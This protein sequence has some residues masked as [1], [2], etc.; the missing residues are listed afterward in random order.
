MPWKFKCTAGD[1]AG[2]WATLPVPSHWDMH[3]FGSLNYRKDPDAAHNEQGL[4]EYEFTVPADWADKR[5]FLVF[6]GSMTDTSAK[7]NGQSVGP[8]HQGSFYRIR[9]EVTKLLKFG[10]PNVLEVT[11]AKHSANESVNRAER[12][13]DYWLF[14]GI[15]R[16]VYLE[17]VPQQFIQRVAIDARADGQFTIDVFTDGTVEGDVLEAQIT[18]LDGEPVDM[19]FRAKA[20][21][22]QT[23][24]STKFDSPRQWSAETPNLYR[25]EVLL[26]RGGK[27]LHEYTQ[28]FG[29]RTF[30][31]RRGDSLFVNGRRVVL[32]GVNR[33][34][35]W[36]E[37]GRC[38]SKDVHRLD[39]ETMKDMNMN[40]VRMSHYPPDAE[41]LDLCDE[42]GLYVLDELAGWHW[43][44]DT[45]TGRK[46]VEETVTRDVNHPS[47]LFWDNGNEGG[48]NKELDEV[49]TQFDPQRRPVLHAWEEFN[50]VNTAHYL[51]YD[52]AVVAAAGAPTR[53]GTG[54]KYE[55]WEDLDDPNKSIYMPTEMLHGLYDGGGGAG[56]D[57]YWTM[58]QQSPL[59]GGGFFWV[60]CDEG[61]K[62]PDTG[63]IDCAGNQAPDGIVGPYRERE[64]SFYTIKELWSPIVV[65]REAKG[66]ITVKNH[67]SFTNSDQCK[68]SWQLLRFPPPSDSSAGF[69]VLSEGTFDAPSI[70]PGDRGPMPLELPP[71]DPPADALAIRVDDPTGRELWT[72][73]WPLAGMSDL[74]MAKDE[75]SVQPVVATKSADA[76]AVAA[77]DL[78][79][80]F[81][82]KTGLLAAVERGDQSFSLTGGPRPAAGDFELK[83]IQFSTDGAD[84]V[85]TA[86]YNGELEQV[87]WR[88]HPNGW[89]D[90]DYRYLA[91]GPHEFHG[92]VFDYPEKLVRGKRWLGDGPWRVWK[93]R[94]R[95]NTLGVWQNEYNDTITGYSGWEYPEFKGCFAKVRWLQL[96]TAEGPITVVPGSQ[97]VF[98]QVLTPAMPPD[99]LIANTKVSLPQAG[100]AL[101]HAIP[102]V[103]SKFKH[104]STSGPQGQLDQA[105]GEFSGSIRF[106]F[107]ALP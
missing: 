48:F 16:P 103:G 90:C 49:F 32:K 87:T 104:A 107:G 25:V 59:L 95:G 42:L 105:A 31:V 23:T 98:V 20:A 70:D 40:A 77:G 8:M 13:G 61:V 58:M 41:F 34:S 36:P 94:L 63:L 86:T 14:G 47:V 51:E 64:A 33:H 100:L 19:P 89:V 54:E 57:D 80:S 101:L 60:F 50:G 81:S 24:L 72:W 10:G 82:T 35:F 85:V 91:S 46:L 97:D 78:E 30:E 55:E 7:L 92:V 3:G 39:I 74:R 22:P 52:R 79:V 71:V 26:Q 2:E 21:G 68:F 1:R 29:F 73:V 84:S 4:Y 67:Y 76:I 106:Y 93:N 9:Y 6:E 17:A 66:T 43:H 28:R 62:R 65:T 96:E 45:P 27:P 44:Y 38:L 18:D 15:F 12:L 75:S 69:E 56:F 11:V 53:H 37:S 99:D 88:V 5:V 102:P 83:D